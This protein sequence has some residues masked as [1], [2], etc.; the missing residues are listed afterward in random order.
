M[1]LAL[2]SCAVLAGGL[3]LISVAASSAYASTG[4]GIERYGLTA[5]N[6]DS[7]ADVQAGSHPY[8]LTAEAGLESG[9]QSASEVRDLTFELPP[10]LT[11]DPS[12]VPPCAYRELTGGTCPNSAAVGVVR[13]S[14][15]QSVV[16]AAVYNLA[17]APGEFARF[18]F[19]LKDTPVIADVTVRTGGDY[20][21]T[22]SIPNIPREEVE[23]VKLMLWGVPADASHDALRGRCVTGEE[24]ICT[25]AAPLSPFLTLPTACAGPL[26]TTL[27]GGSWGAEA[28][29]LPGSFAPMKRRERLD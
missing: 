26:Q 28:A 1:R 9:A 11:L 14:V 12:A 20:G 29:S 21:M 23:S 10:G 19:T 16:P 4:F 22:V 24:T 27:Q 25:D 18:G 6:E 3:V 5:T 17:P 13:M 15:A 2:V 7:S 8:E